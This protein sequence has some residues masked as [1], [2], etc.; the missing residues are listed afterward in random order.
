MWSHP[1]AKIKERGIEMKEVT[2]ILQGQQTEVFRKKSKGID[3][4]C[5]FSL[6]TNSRT[7]DLVAVD[8]KAA[9]QWIDILNSLISG[10]AWTTDN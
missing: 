6:V 4:A 1:G 9:Q 10:A 2:S 5:C 8:S 3:P 7:L